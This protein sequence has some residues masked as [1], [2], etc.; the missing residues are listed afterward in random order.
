[1]KPDTMNRFVQ[2]LKRRRVFRG[3]AVYG[4]STLSLEGIFAKDATLKAILKSTR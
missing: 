2:E 4:A 3:I 1:M